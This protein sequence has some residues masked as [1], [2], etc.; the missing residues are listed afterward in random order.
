MSRLVRLVAATLAVVSFVGCSASPDVEPASTSSTQ[1]AL[2]TPNSTLL[3]GVGGSGFA[4]TK[5]GNNTI[6]IYGRA[7][8]AGTAYVH[9]TFQTSVNGPFS[10]PYQ[11][12][13]PSA[14]VAT[15]V[16][17]GVRASDGATEVVWGNPQQQF[18]R[19]AVPT[20]QLAP[21]VRCEAAPT[22]GNR[23]TGFSD[24][25][26]QPDLRLAVAISVLDTTTQI[27]R[28]F[29]RQQNSDR[30]T[31]GPWTALAAFAY[32]PRLVVD[33][34]GKIHLFYTTDWNATAPYQGA[35][36]H[37]TSANGTAW[38]GYE[39][40]GATGWSDMV[41]GVNQDGR[42]E[43]FMVSATDQ[44]HV[45]YQRWQTALNTPMGSWSGWWRV[46]DDQVQTPF[47]T[48]NQN[49]T[50]EVFAFTI[51]GEPQAQWAVSR[52]QVAP[53]SGWTNWRYLMDTSENILG[54]VKTSDNRLDLF[55][56][57][58]SS[59]RYVQHRIQQS[60]GAW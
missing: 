45:L 41:P 48:R 35:H 21:W 26:T 53:N 19:S 43:V 56:L 50:L 30:S 8:S 34:N 59:P 54:V 5:Q 28:I 58:T 37:Q 36:M 4:F 38:S 60:P 42:L 32:A 57:N 46:S 12:I 40:L 23:I 17:A 25:V 33:N 9:S 51:F 13:H 16:A 49:G 31:W 55:S 10:A 18:C 27:S 52:V 39:Y 44:D 11:R 22:P 29:F 47:V 2:S 3:T 20:N 7:L 1:E 6:R 15:N 14:T 24:I